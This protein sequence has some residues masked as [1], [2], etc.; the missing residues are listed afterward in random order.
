MPWGLVEKGAWW[1]V[2]SSTL[3]GKRG[4]GR[5]RVKAEAAFSF[6]LEATSGFKIQHL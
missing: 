2:V 4:K 1:L 3:R 5:K 6:S